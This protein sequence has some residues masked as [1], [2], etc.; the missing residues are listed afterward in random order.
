MSTATHRRIALARRPDG[1]PV[2]QDFRVETTPTPPMPPGGLL[3]RNLVVSLDAGIR[4]WMNAE[5]TY[6]EPMPLDG[7]VRGMT[8]GQVV[9]SDMPAHKPGTLVRAM[10]GWEE[11]SALQPDAIGLEAV[12]PAP[13]VPIEHY[14]GALGPGGLTA[15]IG[16]YDIGGLRAGDTVLVSAAAGAVGSTVGQIARAAGARTI[17]I[18]GGAAK[19]TKLAELGFDHAIDHRVAPDLT[20]AIRAF[21]PNGVTL[22]FDNVGGPVLEAALPAM[23]QYGRIVA[24]GMIADYNDAE[25]PHGVRTLW[26]MVARR[27]TMRGFFTYDDPARIAP[28]QA[29]LEALLAKGVLVPFNAVREGIEA[30]PQAFVD[31]MAGRTMG[32]T[33][34]RLG[35][36]Q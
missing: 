15:W 3:V 29:G 22:Y 6:M 30:V 1:V 18:A 11:L 33:L 24:C 19:A 4:G 27:L 12:A 32:K 28:A 23:A 17:G 9:A 36:R 14:I 7:T 5:A 31:L 21:A 13:G 16:L 26:Q 25:H 10:A 20:A 2:A 34:V 35:E 8:L